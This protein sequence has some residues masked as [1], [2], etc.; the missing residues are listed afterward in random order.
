MRRTFPALP[1]YEDRNKW[2]YII[3][4]HTASDYGDAE[5]IHR[6]HLKRGWKNGL[7][8]HFIIDN[9]TL[10]HADGEIEVGKRWHDQMDGAHAGVKG[11]NHKAI[12]IGI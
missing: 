12:G 6:W 2:Q 3:V 4:H 9:G 5:T 10:G 7:G 8:Y 1:L 11:W